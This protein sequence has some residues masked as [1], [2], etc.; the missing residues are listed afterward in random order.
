MLGQDV[1]TPRAITIDNYA[2]EVFYLGSNISRNLSLDTETKVPINKAAT[3]LGKL[4][5]CVLKLTSHRHSS[6]NPYLSLTPS[7]TGV[8]T[9]QTMPSKSRR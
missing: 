2:L 3:M 4:A 9:G 6:L 5:T 8:K 7:C 1:D